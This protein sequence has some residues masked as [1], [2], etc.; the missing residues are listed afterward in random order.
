LS[1]HHKPLQFSAKP[2]PFG[3]WFEFN[4]DFLPFTWAFLSMFFEINKRY[5]LVQ[6]RFSQSN[7]V[8][9]KVITKKN[10]IETDKNR[11]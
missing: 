7:L 6:T 2:N 1:G 4:K 9:N 3:N 5:P 8:N 10:P 11:F